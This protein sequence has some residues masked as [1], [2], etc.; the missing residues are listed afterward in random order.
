MK[1]FYG[2]FVR[3]IN[4]KILLRNIIEDTF[5]VKNNSEF[6]E[7]ATLKPAKKP[8]SKKSESKSKKKKELEEV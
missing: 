6:L 4:R 1:L 5:L 7:T 3:C 2:M 8:I